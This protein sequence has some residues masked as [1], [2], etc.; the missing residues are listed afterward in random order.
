MSNVSRRDVLASLAM[1]SASSLAG[2][3]DDKLLA[4]GAKAASPMS[5]VARKEA[6]DKLLKYFGGTA[7]QLLRPAR[8]GCS[9]IRV[10]APSLPGKQ[11]LH[12]LCG[13]G[14]TLWTSAGAVSVC[15][16]CG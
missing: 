9:S 16:C 14:D 4:E 7:P 2:R 15:G 5:A 6:A 8:K 3:A 12:E 10:S 11:Y 1:A 13:T